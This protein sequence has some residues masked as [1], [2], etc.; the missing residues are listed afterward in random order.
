MKKSSFKAAFG[1]FTLFDFFF[2][3]EIQKMKV[4]L[5]AKGQLAQQEGLG[6]FLQVH[7]SKLW[8]EEP[9]AGRAGLCSQDT[10]KQLPQLAGARPPM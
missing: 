10:P 6:V 4:D 1:P 9:K 7:R 8:Q 5:Q 2:L 3:L